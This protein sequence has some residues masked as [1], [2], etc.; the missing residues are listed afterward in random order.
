MIHP[1]RDTPGRAAVY[2]HGAADRVSHVSRNHMEHIMNKELAKTIGTTAREARKNLQLT[3]EDTAERIDVSVEFY[4]R[5][6]R[7]TSVPSI[8]TFAR[9]VSALGVSADAMLGRPSANMNAGTMWTPAPSNE[10]PELRRLLRRL[11]RAE[12]SAL[13]LVNNLLKE[14]ERL[15]ASNEQVAL[16]SDDDSDAQDPTAGDTPPAVVTS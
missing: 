16:A 6:E 7:G 4:A 15:P 10:S 5:I 13:R 11:R 1:V 8:L 2:E 12:P 9:I 3:Q 14:L